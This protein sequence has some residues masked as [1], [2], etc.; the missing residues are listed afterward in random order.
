MDLSA[1]QRY[2]VFAAALLLALA[3]FDRPWA[4]LIVAVAGFGIGMWLVARGQLGRSGIVAALAF[5]LAAA[6]ALFNLLRGR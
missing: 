6:L 5:V 2:V 1:S 4:T 3:A